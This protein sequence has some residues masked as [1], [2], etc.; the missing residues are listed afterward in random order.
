[1][2]VI[3]ELQRMQDKDRPVFELLDQA[4]RLLDTHP[5]AGSIPPTEGLGHSR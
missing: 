2:A 4:L 3:E 5:D 1:M